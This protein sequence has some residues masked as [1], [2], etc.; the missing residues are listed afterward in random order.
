MI[1]LILSIVSS[2][3]ISICMRVSEK[4]IRNQMGMF[5]ANYATCLLLSFLLIEE[6]AGYLAKNMSFPVVGMG[7][8]CGILYLVNF[9]FLKFNMKHNGIVLATTFMK[10]GVLIP[11]LMAI[12][13]FHETPGWTQVIGIV[14]SV[15]AIIIIHFEKDA[16]QEGNKKIWLLLLLML[17]GI[18]DSMAN[19]F[20]QAGAAE[21]KDGYLLVTFFAAFLIAL[22][23][24]LV[25]KTKISGKDILFGILLGIPNYFSARFL[26]QALGSVKAVLVYPMYSVGTIVIIMLAG[27][28]LFRESISKK[29][30]CALGLIVLAL[31]LLNI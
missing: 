18:T 19:I 11:T 9:V 21:A 28:I 13:V 27:V 7:L 23:F 29:K 1:Y 20:E 24:A 3:L 16:I 8:A 15:I 12:V 2:A 10:L 6:K 17:S 22:V 25:S 30:A 4:H 14:L 5:M 31:C 26:L